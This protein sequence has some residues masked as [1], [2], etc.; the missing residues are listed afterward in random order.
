MPTLHFDAAWVWLLAPLVLAWVAWLALKGYAQLSPWARRTS[1]GLRAVIILAMLAALSRPTWDTSTRAQ[2]VIFLLDDSRSVSR[3]NLEAALADIDRLAS[4]ALASG[5]HRVSVIAFGRR[6][7]TIVAARSSWP[8]WTPD[9][10]DLVLHD[11][12]LPEL[13]MRLTRLVSQS[14]PEGE[15]AALK[16][17]IA[18]VEA[19]RDRAIGD[20]TDLRAALRLAQNTGEI[21]EARTIYLFTDANFNRGDTG[22]ALDSVKQAGGTLH[23]VALDKP[24]PPE[25]GAASLTIP[26]TIRVNQTFTADLRLVSTTETTAQVVVYKD[27]YA[28]AEFS[29]PLKAGEN[30]VQV[31]GLFFRDKG[32]HAIEVAVRPA[33]GADT[34]V[35]NNRVK[36]LAS[37]PGELRVLYVD[38]DEAQQSY[39]TSALGLEG[40]Q[41]QARPA[42]G[43]PQT[44][45]DL[46][47]YDAFILSNVPADRL[48]ARQM[49]MI[50]T[51][52][53][54][55]GGGFI[56]VGGDQ[57]FGLGGYFGTPV[58]D[59]LPVSM[60]IQKD[61][62]R[63]SL[64]LELVIDKSGSMEGPKI[65][66][67]K[68]AAVATA[69]A[70]NPRDLIG[71]IGFDSDDQE[72]LP[73]TS[74][75][76]RTTIA[77]AIASLDAG[78]GTFLYPAL[79]TA[80]QRL[81]ES[82]ARRKH[83][84]ILSDGQ[85]QGF[86]YQEMAQML[87]A[88]GITVSTVGIGEDAD[89][90][91]LESIAASG[92]G[93][94]YFT[95]DFNAIPQIF[96]REALRASN[97]ML[98]ERLTLPAVANP[99]E[100]IAELDDSD[101]PPLNGYVATTLKPDAKLVLAT[102][103][104][105]PLLA[106]WRS[107]LG[108]TAAFTSDTKPR[109]AEDWIRWAD[110][111]KF[112]AQLVRSVA[113]QDVARDVAV[114]PTRETRDD[115]VRLTA[116]LRD[117]SG[118]LLTDQAV[119]LVRLDPDAGI[120]P[121][122]VERI[123]PGLFAGTVPQGEFGRTQQFAWRLPDQRGETTSVP[124]GF[125]ES[126]S[127]EFQTL[128]VDAGQLKQLRDRGLSVDSAG[129]ARLALA[130]TSSRRSR[131]L[132]PLLLALALV[133]APLDILVRRLG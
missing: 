59:I 128:G 76:D 25:V 105:D 110:F 30:S 48:S 124:F 92:A 82:A 127:P 74:A 13:R 60:P 81:Q 95:N 109:W 40:I 19:F 2:H 126:Y 53:Q 123:A 121:V 65:Q 66:L 43:V 84:I 116:E 130:E 114:E 32:F 6:P 45:E 35:E 7:E 112:W 120:Q 11:S 1:A 78:G 17:H 4:E 104:A 52:V 3:E 28:S 61:L 115:R 24:L 99:D 57:S 41:V 33:A 96:T 107:G 12:A 37:V 46:L 21:G 29:Q 10:R 49:Q 55:F 89:I 90:K 125:V 67:A 54:D 5:P 88:D 113:G 64:A 8:G 80:Q 47:G 86:G 132:W 15:Q 63:P 36:A 51:Y 39:L 22:A 71:V 23:V 119:E 16:D 101:L 79:E 77:T 72:I 100:S 98:V 73:L 38:T 102:D 9:T 26:P 42:S 133:L 85:T 27:G 103:N 69:E 87:A 106:R 44:L 117:V 56:M 94:A 91:L 83:V 131:T 118:R 70:I 34:R 62:N 108:R 68:R 14:A 31:P 111:A 129:A 75:G 20:A 58:E 18:H 93:R 122:P 97:S 50:R